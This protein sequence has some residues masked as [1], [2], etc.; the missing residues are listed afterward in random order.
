MENF[1]KILYN[2]ILENTSIVINKLETEFND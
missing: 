1:E 2:K